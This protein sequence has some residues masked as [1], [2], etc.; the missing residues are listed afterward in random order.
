VTTYPHRISRRKIYDLVLI[1]TELDW[2]EIRMHELQHQVDYFVV[3]E[4]TST[5][6]RNPKPVHVQSNFD[7]FQEFHPK[8]IYHALNLDHIKDW[9]AWER[10][11]Y[12]RTPLFDAVF[13]SLLGPRSG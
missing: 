9:G 8:I 3:L 7:R 5:F 4:A 1:D 10:E 13:P 6:T 2:L 12:C 11:A